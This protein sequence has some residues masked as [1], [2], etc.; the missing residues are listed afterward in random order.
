VWFFLNTL[1][2]GLYIGMR[3]LSEAIIFDNYCRQ[4]DSTE[5]LVKFIFGLVE[6][7]DKGVVRLYGGESG[8]LSTV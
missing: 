5:T 8:D 1:C 4:S 7:L 6:W 3:R 2:R